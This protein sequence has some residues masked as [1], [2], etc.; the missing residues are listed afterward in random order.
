MAHYKHQQFDLKGSG[1]R[2]VRLLS[3]DTNDEIECELIHATLD[4]NILP[5]EAVSY[6]WGT[7]DMSNNIKVNGQPFMVTPNQCRLLHDL[8]ENGCD[9]LLRVDSICINQDDLRERTHQVKQM[10]TIYSKAERVLLY[11]GPPTNQISMLMRCLSILKEYAGGKCW[12]P[13]DEQWEIAWKSMQAESRDHFGQNV[14]AIQRHGLWELL[15]RPWFRRV[16]ILQE[17]ANARKAWLYCGRF[18]VT[19]QVFAISPRLLEVDLDSHC[20]AV[21]R[22]MPTHSHIASRKP[23]HGGLLSLLIDFYDAEASDPRDKIF[24][25]LGL[26]SDPKIQ[27]SVVPDYEK[28]DLD[29]VHDVVSHIATGGSDRRPAWVSSI[30]SVPILTFLTQLA[31]LE[32]PITLDRTEDIFVRILSALTSEGVLCSVPIGMKGHFSLTRD[33]FEAAASRK[34]DPQSMVTLL[35]ACS[36]SVNPPTTHEYSSTRKSIEWILGHMDDTTSSLARDELHRLY[37]RCA[38]VYIDLVRCA[39]RPPSASSLEVYGRRIM[40]EAEELGLL[41]TLMSFQSS[42]IMELF[43]RATWW[44]RSVFERLAAKALY[45]ATLYQHAPTVKYLRD[46]WRGISRDGRIMW[47]PN[48]AENSIS[49][50]VFTS[51]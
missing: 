28:D 5:Y 27:Q 6:A 36:T 35:M 20:A 16:W 51:S 41:A 31:S 29:I 37:N 22:L 45:V 13:L 24:A 33:L 4:E 21:F 19:V 48:L 9:R 47:N 25:L 18:H 40:H 42:E 17:V 2:L 39:K 46:K 50:A 44:K 11:L 8:R 14:E 26:C 7:K 1:F 34:D 23:R 10:K 30:P 49:L 3:G 38:V 12:E 43:V 15:Q 32:S